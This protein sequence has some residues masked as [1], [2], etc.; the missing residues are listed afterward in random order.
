MVHWHGFIDHESGIKLYRVA[1]A[2]WCLSK[3]ELFGRNGT[4]VDVT[5]MEIDSSDNTIRFNANFTG[6]RYVSVL[7][8][9]NAMEPSD[10][11]CSDG[12]TKGNS[13]P[14]FLNVSLANAKWVESI[15]CND[16]KTWLLRNDLVKVEL[17]GDENCRQTCATEQQFPFP[18]SL[19]S[20]QLLSVGLANDSMKL[21]NDQYHERADFFC[22]ELPRY[23][24][25]NVIYIPNDQLSMQWAV[26]DGIQ[27]HDFY[28]GFGNDAS[29]EDLP[30]ILDYVSTNRMTFFKLHHSGIGT[31]KEFFVFLKGVNKA[32][33]ATILTIGPVIID[34]T[35]PHIKSAPVVNIEADFIYVGWA[36][37]SFD[38]EEQTEPIN[39]IFFQIG[40]PVYFNFLSNNCNRKK[41][42]L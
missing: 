27:V 11:A 14:R 16:N 38:D 1:L 10:V 41:S 15:Y 35:P 13:P 22:S 25:T 5:V 21:L 3:Q 12:I 32:S 7:A 4:A 9:N 17:H 23:N 20:P 26:A 36:K 42:V 40:I 33:I 30:G 28:V 6:K 24:P 19:L 29:E 31:D 18:D 8:L 2:T 37:E 39:Q 34:E